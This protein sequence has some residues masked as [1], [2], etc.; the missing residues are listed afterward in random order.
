MRSIRK[1]PSPSETKREFKELA[2]EQMM[3]ASKLLRKMVRVYADYREEKE[4]R[5]L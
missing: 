4:L 2:E 1:R 5:R 3:G